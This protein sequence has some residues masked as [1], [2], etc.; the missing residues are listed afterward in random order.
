MTRDMFQF[1]NAH[2][3]VAVLIFDDVNNI[4]NDTF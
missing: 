4:N 1:T 3:I 2:K